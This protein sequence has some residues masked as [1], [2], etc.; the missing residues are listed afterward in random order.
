MKLTD[1]RGMKERWPRKRT[2]TFTGYA[3]TIQDEYYNN[4]LSEVEGI[5]IEL[6]ESALIELAQKFCRSH[7]DPLGEKEEYAEKLGSMICFIKVALC[8]HAKEIVKVKECS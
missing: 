8:S 2:N 3:P 4:A 7:Y 6:D 5:E 1:I